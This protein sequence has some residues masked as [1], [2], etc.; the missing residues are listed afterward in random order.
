MTKHILRPLK[1]ILPM[2]VQN[3]LR[4][5]R[6]AFE[7]PDPMTKVMNEIE[8]RD[9]PLKS[10]R[11]LEVFGR[12]GNW[13]TKAYASRVRA[14]EV[15][16]IQEQYREPLKTNLPMAEVKITDSFQEIR[17]TENRYELV[18]VDNSLGTFR[19]DPVPGG[20]VTTY[21]EH[22]DLFPHVFRVLAPSSV[23]IL[24]VIPQINDAARK[25]YPCLFDQVQLERRR[26]FYGT[27][28]P[29][30]MPL[31][32]IVNAYEKLIVA[33]GFKLDWSFF[34]QRGG[35]KIVHY[36]VLKIT[37]VESGMLAA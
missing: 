7:Q 19:D 33:N 12:D 37:R 36:L 8:R 22:F 20:V 3:G 16:E 5:L 9:V 32:E 14:L 26:Q 1:R 4:R 17:G 35:T 34:Q 30:H 6:R 15:W 10:L 21:C 2:P 18:V 11:A 25:K 23:L 24:N 27:S 31:E 13:H 29:D 28:N